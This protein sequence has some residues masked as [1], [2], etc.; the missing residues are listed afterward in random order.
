MPDTPPPS[1]LQEWER[2]YAMAMHLSLLACGMG[3]PLV[4]AVVMHLLKKDES[5][6]VAAHGREVINFQLSLLLYAVVGTLTIPLCGMG[7]VLLTAV[8]VLGLVGLSFG[9]VAAQQGKLFVY[10]VCIRFL[11]EP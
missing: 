11:R 1:L 6:F 5:R 2:N 7:F 3:V 10:P 9:A 4:P 8:V